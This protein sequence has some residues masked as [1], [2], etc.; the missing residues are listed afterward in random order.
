MIFCRQG[1]SGKGKQVERP[2][3]EN[4]YLGEVEVRVVLLGWNRQ[5]GERKG[6]QRGSQG[7][8]LHRAWQVCGQDFGLF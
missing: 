3:D 6:G 5:V 4:K 8:L 7:T 1:V 2:G